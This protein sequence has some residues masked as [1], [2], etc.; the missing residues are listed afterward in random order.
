MTD[1][2]PSAS[3]T[4]S[5]PSHAKPLHQHVGFEVLPEQERIKVSRFSRR[6]R[7]LHWFNAIAIIGL[8]GLAI[9]S[10]ISSNISFQLDLAD[11]R[12]WHIT[13]GISWII[14]IPVLW[15][16]TRLQIHRKRASVISDQLIIKQRLFLFT[17]IALMTSMAFS[18]SLL[19]LLRP[20]N[21]PQ[22]RSIILLLHGFIAFAYL[23]LLATHIYLAIL[24][25]DSR[26]SLR[27]MISDVQIKYLIHNHIPKLQC[28]LS[29]QE[30]ILFI[31]GDI[32][33]INLRGFHVRIDQGS[34]QKSV[35][36]N[37]LVN[38]A[39]QH[40]ELTEEL[41][42]PISI[43]SDYVKDDGLHVNFNFNLPLQEVSRLLLSRGLFFRALFL[44]RRHY[45]RLNCHYPVT[46]THH[47]QSMIAQAIDI[48]PG[49]MGIVVPL[50]LSKGDKVHIH[51]QL[52]N[53]IIDWHT[54]ALIVVK[55]H[56]RNCDYSYGLC[57][58]NLKKSELKQLSRILVH[59]KNQQSNKNIH[60]WPST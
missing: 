44:A 40:P 2:T 57:F 42:L 20:Y 19:T 31:K 38:V 39:F 35:L 25:R 4:S 33:E 51:L 6:I 17:S 13:L 32:I 8:Y 60:Y 36:L 58:K 3:D 22:L 27:T 7:L 23:P 45:P 29:D 10:I 46:I 41:I 15:L 16:I 56:I 34:W 1:H 24:Q 14:G 59:I 26:Q 18:G 11:L 5:E 37:Q 50:R 53:P 54:E 52:K 21:I 49:G 43:Y 55:S 30:G 47:T 48:G 12:Q 28:G 9:Q